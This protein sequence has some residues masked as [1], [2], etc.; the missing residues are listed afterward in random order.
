ME[1]SLSSAKGG[2]QATTEDTLESIPLCIP[3]KKGFSPMVCKVVQDF[4]HPQSIAFFS[5]GPFW[6]LISQGGESCFVL[7]PKYGD[8][9]RRNIPGAGLRPSPMKPL[10]ILPPK[11]DGFSFSFLQWEFRS[12]PPGQG[13]MGRMGAAVLNV[14]HVFTIGFQA[15]RL[16]SFWFP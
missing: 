12:A 8:P 2:V 7:Q 1:E 9:K 4:V 16:L 11:S 5:T 3:T 15:N 14:A 13:R 10:A 6:G